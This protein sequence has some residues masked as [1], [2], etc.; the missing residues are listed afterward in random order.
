M[1]TWENGIAVG[2]ALEQLKHHEERITQT[3][4]AVHEVRAEVGTIR[5]YLFRGLLLV[6]LWAVGLG[7]NW[8]A[9]QVGETLAATLKAMRK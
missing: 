8:S 2:R 7:G 5:G 6:L 9:E 1:L 3:E 4:Q